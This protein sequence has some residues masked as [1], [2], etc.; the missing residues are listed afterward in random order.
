[1]TYYRKM[2]TRAR[3]EAIQWQFSLRGNESYGEMYVAQARF[4][5]L[6]RR[7]GLTR[8]FRENCII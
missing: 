7:Y 6:G 8:E 1:M 4:E 3:D 5:K 2:K